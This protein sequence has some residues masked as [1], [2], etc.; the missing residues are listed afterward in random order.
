MK[1][2]VREKITGL[3]VFYFLVALVAIGATLHV[4]WQLEGG[5]AAINE[6]G[7]ERMQSYRIAYLLA[8]QVQHPSPGLE[9]DIRRQISQ[10]EMTF[11]ELQHGNPQRP[12]FLPREV[13][14]QSQMAMLSD[15]WHQD[16]KPRIVGILESR[17][18][19]ERMERFADYQPVLDGFVEGVNQLVTM[20]EKSNARATA[21]LRTIQI[22]LI[23][24]ALLGT[25][26]LDY[27]FSL[28]LV[29]PVQRLHKGLRSMG[30]ADFGV[31]LPATRNDEL[32]EIAQGFNQMAEKLEDIYSTLEQRVADKTRGIETKNRELAALYEVAAFLNSCSTAEPLCDNVLARM[33]SLMGARGGVVRLTD[34]KGE[35][36]RV[37]AAQ[38]VSAPFLG[39]EAV[40]AVGSC[41]CGEVARD[42]IAVSSDCTLPSSKPL[43]N[44]CSKA[45]YRAIAAVPI[46]S[47]QRVLG[48]F[49]LFFDDVRILPPS[50]VRLLESVGLH[51]GIAIENQRL[52]AREREMAVSEER[53]LL[54]Q[55]LH[56]SIAQSLAFLNIQVQLLQ[57]YLDKANVA[58][59]T[60]ILGQIREGVQ[61]SY[62]DVRELLVHFR[63][64]LEHAD[65]ENAIRHA[66]EKFE[67]Q[68]GIK[69]RYRRQGLAPDMPPEHMLQVLYILQESLS[70][71][72]KHSG[73]TRVEVVL[74]TDRHDRLTVRDNGKGFDIARHIGDTHVGIRIMRERAHRFGGALSIASTPGKGT[75]VSLT[76]NPAAITH[77]HLDAA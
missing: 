60:Q 45:G 33:V 64:R 67:G 44:A 43:L 30:Q 71:I 42:G 12:L 14:I 59:A 72:R 57:E 58:N 16:M 35:Q 73:A 62:D 21:T 1:L 5:A 39:E 3:L 8:Q 41:V 55:E 6:G 36:L 66:L 52:A 17:N 56:D 63:T 68:V 20:V 22:S 11:L 34:P 19:R 24:V 47:S 53:N 18:A 28:L 9:D 26:L 70:N 31:R 27:L 37:V 61:E 13:A 51:L 10:F 4:S 54:A 69:T 2:R 49:N 29:K 75:T 15:A 76:W 7:R 77:Q 38:G 23:V 65:L 25:I 48:M 46:R 32:G 74:S 50:E 40:L